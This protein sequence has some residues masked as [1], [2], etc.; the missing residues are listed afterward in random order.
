MRAKEFINESKTTLNNMYGGHFPDRDEEFWDYVTP[1]ELGQALTVET[2]QK[3][4]VLIMLLSQYRAEHIDDITDML[5]DDQQ[6]I[7][8]SYVNDPALSSKT[9]VVA[10]NKIIDGNHRALAAAIKGV[11]INYVNLAELDEEPIDESTNLNEELRVDVPNEEWLQDAIDYAKSKSPDRNGLPYMGKTTASVRNVDVPLSILRRIPGMRQEQSK[12]R[13]RDLAAIRKIMSTTGKLPLHGHT[14]QE[15]KPF[16]NVAYDGSAWVNEGNHRIM[17]AAELGWDSLPVEIS[18]FD[19]GERIKDGAMYPG[20]IGLGEPP[21][22]EAEVGTTNAK[23]IATQLKAAGYSNVGTG[24]D[25]TV[26]AKDENYIIKILMPED[27]GT[28][29]EQVFRKFYEFAMSHQDLECMPRFNEVNTIDINSKDYTQIEMERLAP[30]EKG[31]FM[32]GV[33]WFFSDFCQARE[34]WDKVDHAMGLSDTWEWYPYAKSSKSIANVYIRQWQ[35]L[36]YDKKSYSMYR[37]LYNVMKLLYNTGTIN[38]FGWDLHTA[39][40]MQRKNG[41]PV[42]IDPWFS[43]GTS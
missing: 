2:M 1:R 33:I 22:D 43:E 15:Y 14:G 6:E 26:W 38:K 8:Q 25:S 10:N 41:Q 7:V 32:E 36:V 3:H 23:A 34:S 17:A 12:I 19:G 5:D 29:A 31:T 42:I 20:R 13:H 18:Y 27:L 40:V 21:L 37:Q 9:I 28:K 39:N 11:P 30:I 16:I 24:A 35:D 4:K